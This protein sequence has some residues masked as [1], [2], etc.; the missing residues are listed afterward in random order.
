MIPL[1]A[2]MVG[3][4]STSV[5]NHLRPKLPDLI[6]TLMSLPPC[7]VWVHERNIYKVLGVKSHNTHGEYHALSCIITTIKK[8][9]GGNKRSNTQFTVDAKYA[10][11]S[12]QPSSD[13]THN[14]S[15]SEHGSLEYFDGGGLN[16]DA[17]LQ[18][19]HWF[20]F[21]HSTC[22]ELSTQLAIIAEATGDMSVNMDDTT[23]N[24]RQRQFKNFIYERDDDGYSRS[25]IPFIAYKFYH[26]LQNVFKTDINMK[27]IATKKDG[28]VDIS[29]RAFVGMELNKFEGLLR[30]MLAAS[31]I[32]GNFR[33][34]NGTWVSSLT[35]RLFSASTGAT[36]TPRASNT[37]AVTPA[38][39]ISGQI[40]SCDFPLRRS[41]STEIPDPLRQSLLG[42]LLFAL[43][44]H[45]QLRKLI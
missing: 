42:M 38:T 35:D 39:T 2:T 37:Q 30:Q 21:G 27:Y 20:R 41:N 33:V 19:P 18:K 10:G 14:V 29:R 26:Q 12:L 16:D 34:S 9:K 43:L 32:R 40:S 6:A 17:V 3:V 11:C 4:N 22:C 1:A 15:F 5:F 36:A 28:T 24:R 7:D 8:G 31:T 23:R 25:D 45:V 13:N 44:L